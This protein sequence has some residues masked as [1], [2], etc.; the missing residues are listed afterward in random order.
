MEMGFDISMV[1]GTSVGALNGAMVVQG[2]I[3]PA[4]D[5]WHELRPD[6]VI[7]LDNDLYNG[8]LASDYKPG[9]LESSCGTSGK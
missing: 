6:L 2:D 9:T 8:L 7:N 3:G 1:A 5:I 4:Y